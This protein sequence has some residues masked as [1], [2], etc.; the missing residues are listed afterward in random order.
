[1]RLTV[2]HYLELASLPKEG[3][4]ASLCLLYCLPPQVGQIRRGGQKAG[5]PW[6][7]FLRKDVLDLTPALSKDRSSTFPARRSNNQVCGLRD[8]KFHVEGHMQLR[9]VQAEDGSQESREEVGGWAG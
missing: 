9:V 4:G 1:M 2:T 6:G 7:E 5:H 8:A 3:G